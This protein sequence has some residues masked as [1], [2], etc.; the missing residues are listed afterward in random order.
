MV[1]LLYKRNG[2]LMKSKY[3]FSRN[4][5]KFNLWLKNKVK[6]E[7]NQKLFHTHWIKFRRNECLSNEKLKFF[8][9]IYILYLTLQFIQWYSNFYQVDKLISSFELWTTIPPKIN[10]KV[11]E[12]SEL[13][14]LCLLSWRNSSNPMK[15]FHRSVQQFRSK[16]LLQFWNFTLQK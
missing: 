2:H 12:I 7:A 16:F 14:I 11:F 10:C 8:F 1:P 9:F 13:L 5:T 6:K 3:K 4:G 15:H